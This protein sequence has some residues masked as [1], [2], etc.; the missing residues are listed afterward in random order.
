[1]LQSDRFQTGSHGLRGSVEVHTEKDCFLVDCVTQVCIIRVDIIDCIGRSCS[2]AE[3]DE[4]GEKHVA[5]SLI[6][7]LLQCLYDSPADPETQTLLHFL[8]RTVQV[9]AQPKSGFFKPDFKLGR[10]LGTVAVLC[11][12]HRNQLGCLSSPFVA[13]L[14]LAIEVVFV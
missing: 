10:L 9:T 2:L 7:A 14:D 13:S 6:T 8:S 4:I 5:L 11:D 12:E 3:S 1:M